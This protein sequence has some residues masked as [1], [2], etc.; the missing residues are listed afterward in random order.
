[1]QACTKPF[2]DD[3]S[4]MIN[5]RQK[6]ICRIYY[7]EVVFM[8]DFLLVEQLHRMMGELPRPRLMYRKRGSVC[9]DI[10][11]SIDPSRSRRVRIFFATWTGLFPLR[12][13]FSGSAGRWGT[14]DTR[15]G[16]S[17]GSPC[18]CIRGQASM[19]WCVRAC[20]CF[21]STEAGIFWSWQNP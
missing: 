11:K 18:D 2:D 8:T 1:M 6:K 16:I 4:I 5:S 13:R 3:S 20:R 14:A 19:M 15:A 12:A 10:L 17:R 9:G 7:R 21:L